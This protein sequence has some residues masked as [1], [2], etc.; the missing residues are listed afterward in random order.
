MK[1]IYPGHSYILNQLDAKANTKPQRLDFVKRL[2]HHSPSPGVTNQE[3]IRV[4]ID[5]VKFLDAE[6]PNDVNSQIVYH[7]RMALVL[8]EARA[9]IRAVEKGKLIPE[10]T[11]LDDDG[12][13][14]LR[15]DNEN[16]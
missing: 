6:L 4:L 7:L 2:P 11:L 9:M 12:H 5:R 16:L 1:V 3:V 14:A 15:Y 8:H 13:F 10:Q